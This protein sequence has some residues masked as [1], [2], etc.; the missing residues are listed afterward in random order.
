MKLAFQLE[1]RGFD[2]NDALESPHGDLRRVP[3]ARRSLV[4]AQAVGRTERPRQPSGADARHYMRML[5]EPRRV[6]DSRKRGFGRFDYLLTLDKLQQIADASVHLR[7]SGSVEGRAEHAARPPS[8]RILE[9]DANR[10]RTETTVLAYKTYTSKANRQYLRRRGMAATLP[11]KADQDA[12]RRAKGSNGGRPPAFDPHLYTQC[13][14]MECG[15][16]RL[17]A[18][19]RSHPFR[20]ASRALRGPIEL[21]AINEWL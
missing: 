5:G 16:N 14:A 19:A 15:I 13:H 8:P 7:T 21:A 2:H 12:H 17:G 11:S 4:G 20:Q 9:L 18:T 10:T 6:M 3:D 1:F